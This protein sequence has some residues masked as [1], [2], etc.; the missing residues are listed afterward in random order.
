MFFGKGSTKQLEDKDAEI[1]SLQKKLDF[2][3]QLVD[4]C[5]HMGFI[6][7]RDHKIVFK[8]G[9][10][11]NMEGIDSK[12]SDLSSSNAD[13]SLNNRLY[14]TKSQNI[15]GTLYHSVMQTSD[16]LIECGKNQTFNLYHTS[17]REGLEELQATM[18]NIF[19]NTDDLFRAAATGVENSK[20]T[21]EKVDK[22]NENITSLHEKMQSAT[23]LADSLSQRSSEITQVISLIDDIAE[24]TNLLALNAAIEAARAGEHGRGFAVVADEVRKLAEKT[25]KATK[26]IAV[27]VKSMQQ[28]ASDIQTNTHET[29]SIAE[30]IKDDVNNMRSLLQ[31]SLVAADTANYSIENLNNLAFCCL[32]KTDHV[33]YK[34]NLYGVI[35]DI[36]NHFKIVDNHNCRL[37]KWYYEGD[38]KK[39]FSHMPSY[40]SMEACHKE[41]HDS[42]NALVEQLKDRS[43]VSSETIEKAVSAVERSSKEVHNAIDRISQEKS[44]ELQKKI[45]SISETNPS[46]T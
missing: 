34:G 10:I 37:G 12:A 22:A 21:I 16:L 17:M 5:S 28:E 36:P 45:A 30:V 15:D 1:K 18:Q 3:R 23:S 6:G 14:K 41:V 8:T 11:V 46:N 40:R 39:H 7:V 26:E 19:K 25:Q 42:A 33:V 44:E 9:E 13:F 24:Q 2:Y 27:V 31:G 35:F 32:A 4:L 38:G 29:N 20:N 43:K